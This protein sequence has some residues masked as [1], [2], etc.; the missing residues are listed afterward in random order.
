MGERAREAHNRRAA[1]D[2]TTPSPCSTE[3]GSPVPPRISKVL[4]VYPF[5]VTEAYDIHD[6]R[7]RNVEVQP[8]LGL[9]YLS[10]YLKAFCPEV[11][12]E[13]LD[14]N[15]MAV[16]RCLAE[17]RV[18]MPA[19]WEALRQAIAE[20]RPDLVGISCLFHATAA[21]A[22]RTAALAKAVDPD[23]LTVMGGN[24]A[25]VSWDEALK[26][27]NLDVVVFS[28]GEQRLVDLVRAINSGRG[29]HAVP[30]IA[31]RGADGA[32]ARGADRDLIPDIDGIPECDRSGFDLGFYAE[33]GRQFVFRFLDRET[34]RITT[35]IASRGCP[36]RCTF[37]SARLVWGGKIRY[38]SATLVVDEMQRLRDR[39]GINAFC[40]L[41]DNLLA[42]KR[43]FLKLADEI[44]RRMP[45][46][47]WVSLGGMQISSLS[48]DVIDAIVRSGCRW[49]ILPAESGNPATLRKICKPHTPESVRR[50]IA[51]IRRLPDT[52][53]AAN[54]V[55][56]FPFEKMADI[57][58][59]FEYVRRLDL[60]WVYVF[61]FMPLPGTSMYEECVEA[62]YTPA[63][64]HQP[65]QIGELGVLNTPSLDAAEVAE[66]NYAFNAEV[67][68]L[69]N[70]NI[71]ARPA[72]AIRDFQY[73]LQTARHNPLAMYG[74]AC[75]YERLGDGARAVEWL[76]RALAEVEAEAEAEAEADRAPATENQSAVRSISKSFLVVNRRI[77]YVQYFEAQGID[78]RRR[79]QQ[80]RELY[81]RG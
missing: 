42:V 24:Y 60:D 52:W 53:I 37:C 45:G 19:L 8:P 74:L 23:I 26:D 27:P 41:D 73:V 1:D 28:E 30:G 65:E 15:A 17:D 43:E 16:R 3:A 38:R 77:R 7:N 36:H 79:L 29:W 47:H 5:C 31:W 35:L 68:F 75:A 67:N 61:R 44:A 64:R 48:D 22:H 40:F 32:P 81:K 51:S 6:V 34:T 49:F 76:G 21:P 10:A 14:A 58:E 9:G 13:V 71:T 63:Y 39:Q 50:V 70:R 25:H 4:L 62:G 66:R 78:L 54:I 56:G 57:E 59:G 12:V 20:R 18:D 69:R 46:V 72:Q 2:G 55:T 80:A 11:T 33:Q